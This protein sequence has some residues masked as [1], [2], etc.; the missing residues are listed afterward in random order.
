M[1]FERRRSGSLVSDVTEDWTLFLRSAR[2]VDVNQDDMMES[3][4]RRMVVG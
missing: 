3:G 1:S 2:V 4:W